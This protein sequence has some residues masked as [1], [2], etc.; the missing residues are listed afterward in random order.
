MPDRPPP[1]DINAPLGG[2]RHVV[3][4][5]G[6]TAEVPRSTARLPMP[7]GPE[8]GLVIDVDSYHGALHPEAFNIMNAKAAAIGGSLMEA[9]KALGV[10]PQ[11][12]SYSSMA[13]MPDS[14][15]AGLMQWPG[16]NP[17]S[18]RKICRENLAPRMIWN[19]RVNDVSRYAKFAAMP[20]ETGWYVR[21]RDPDE[22]PT[23][24]DR[25][26]MK[27]CARF[28]LNCCR[29]GQLDPETFDPRDRDAAG[30]FS[31]DTFLRASM[32]DMMT[33]DAW[34][35]W[36]DRA[37]SGAINAFAPMPAG[38][39]RL[40]NPRHGYQ[41]NE[42]LFA[43]LLDETGSPVTAFTRDQLVWRVQYPRTDPAA[44][45][46]GWSIAEQIVRAIQ[47]FQSAV[48]LNCGTFDKSGIPN[49]I[50]K[51]MGDFWNQDQIDAMMREWNNMKRG[52]TKVWGMPII[53][54]PEDADIEL[55]NLNDVK[56][57]DV[58]YRDHMNMMM[59]VSCIVANFPIRRLGLFASGHTRDNM[60][61]PEQSVEI[62]GVDDPGMPPLLNHIEDTINPYIV[63]AAW[64]RLAVAFRN[65]DPKSDARGYEI[66]KNAR[67]W[68]ESRTLT[69]QDDLVKLATGDRAW[70]KPV[71]QIMSL[72]PE[73]PSKQGSFQ[74][75]ATVALQDKLKREAMEE[76]AEEGLTPDGKP[77]DEGGGEKTPESVGAPYPS[78]QDPA[79]SQEH[80][81]RAGVTRPSRREESRADSGRSGSEARREAVH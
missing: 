39:I 21:M 31:F 55:L 52:V 66:M 6:V 4:P 23:A 62:Q 11:A 12:Y 28:V 68:G 38:N 59:G 18:L 50:L 67:T 32:D 34:A 58:R 53:G 37:R 72:C 49:A 57:Q 19:A 73:D 33:F 46:Y 43:A 61:V 8:R 3:L 45:G 9:A 14:A 16:I 35:I 24:Q 29:E 79:A 44:W 41:N 81:H 71:M 26:D 25:R 2:S 54:V 64:P 69:D 48:D 51:L 36:T 75:I 77:L 30:I 78:K 5:S 27:E 65:K 63:Q 17:D 13:F 20:W 47:G 7:A 1:F 56:G 10:P 74:T 70:L 15:N 60:P 76:A 80:G 42:K 22:K 40:A